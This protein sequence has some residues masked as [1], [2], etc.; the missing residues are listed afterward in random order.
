MRFLVRVNWSHAALVAV[1]FLLLALTALSI[2]KAQ[3]PSPITELEGYAWS[4]TIGWVSMNCV[5][6]GVCGSSDYKVEIM[7]DFTLAGYGWSSNIGWVKFGGLSGCPGGSCDARVNTDTDELEGWAR[8]CAGTNPGDCSTMTD[9]IDGWD[10]WISLN[11]ANTGDCASS[12][13]MVKA[14]TGG[15]ITCDSS[16]Q[17]CA[18]GS[19]VVGWVDW[20]NVTFDPPYSPGYYACE[21]DPEARKHRNQWGIND[22]DTPCGDGEVCSEA[23]GYVCKVPVVP[24]VNDYFADP[25]LVRSA[26]TTVITWDVSDASE[27]RVEGGQDSWNAT[28]SSETTSPIRGVVEYTL[29]CTSI[30]GGSEMLLD[31]LNVRTVPAASEI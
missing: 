29:Y 5:D 13:Y 24:T 2:T 23:A 15:F 19:D 14:N 7:D 8:A 12:N 1:I 27:C 11:C 10:G 30:D 22:Y 31:T 21:H 26:E 25:E 6:E 17:S 20:R 18:W 3:S 4:S 9:H 28:S 16:N